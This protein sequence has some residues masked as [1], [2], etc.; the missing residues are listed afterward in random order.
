MSQR[1]L[2]CGVSG[3][4]GAYLTKLLLEKGYQVWGTSRDA[5][6]ASFS[7][8][9]LLGLRDQVRLT[10]LNLR[11]VSGVINLVNRV[12]PHEIYNLAAQ[13]SV[14]LSFEQPHE[15]FESIVLGGLNLLEAIRL[16]KQPVRLYN[17]GSTEC[18][19]DTGETPVSEISPFN[20]RSPYAV[21]K[22]AAH[23]AVSNYRDAY[24]MYA[25]TG[26]LSNHD[27]P[28]RPRRFVTRKIVRAVAELSRGHTG[29]LKL[30]TLGIERDWGWA[31]DYVDAIWR[32]LQQE[33][34]GDFIIATGLTSTLEQFVNAAYSCIG[35]NWRNHVL[36]DENLFRPS[37]IIHSRMDPTKAQTHL[38]WRATHTMPAVVRLMF[39]EE[40]R[41]IEAGE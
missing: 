41:R 10:S 24:G 3:Q 35:E 12:K 4:D 2:V 33:T 26:V 14:G 8:L 17:A 13:S 18:F 30:G 21:A 38:G 6:M 34:P 32:I 11:D 37:D 9:Q 1:A 19:G 7:N 36:I 40:I 28:L 27:S 23:W 16:S 29:K 15:T 20:P 25:C 5:E 31:P 39:E 22:A